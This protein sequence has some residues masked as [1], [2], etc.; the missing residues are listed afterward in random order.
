MVISLP[1]MSAVIATPPFQTNRP[2][3]DVAQ[4][5]VANAPT[6]VHSEAAGSTTLAPSVADA[7]DNARDEVIGGRMDHPYNFLAPQRRMAKART[8]ESSY[9][10]L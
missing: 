6:S 10:S 8:S 4:G 9:L 2:E 1:A 7:A 5:W 3:T